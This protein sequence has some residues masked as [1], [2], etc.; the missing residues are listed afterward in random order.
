MGVLA[1]IKSFEQRK[2]KQASFIY[3]LLGTSS[4]AVMTS[5]FKVYVAK[6][7]MIQIL[8]TRFIFSL[9]FLVEIKLTFILIKIWEC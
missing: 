4:G 6:Y 9:V 5:V 8:S 3:M 2:A 1:N 7:S